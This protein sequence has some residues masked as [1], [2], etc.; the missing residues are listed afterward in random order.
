MG[1]PA[2]L[3]KNY[4]SDLQYTG[5]TIAANEE[6]SDHE[7]WRVADGRRSAQDYWTPTTA[8]AAAWNKVDCAVSRAGD[9][10]ALDRGHNLGGKTI[11]LQKS[12]D[13]FSGDTVDVFTATI[14][15]TVSDDTAL[16]ATNGALTP[17]GAWVKAFTSTSSRY[18]RLL[19]NA[20]GAGEKPQ[21]V[22]WFLGEMW[23]PDYLRM[24]M[25]DEDY[26]LV[27]GETVIPSTGW[28]GR[29]K[30]VQQRLGEV[31]AR[32]ADASAYQTSAEHIRDRF[33]AGYPMW[34]V[35]DD[36]AAE[37]TVLADWTGQQEGF[38]FAL[39][40]YPRQGRFSW[41]ERAAKVA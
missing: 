11:K 35:Y 2:F 5:H 14:P 10:V 34:I 25:P 38:R 6:A 33:F 3:V 13:D 21:V 27:Y 19:V 24:P 29:T 41:T 20:M 39:G 16:T 1:S 37:R 9:M 18:W 40:W 36:A 4:Y 15:T 17:E 30:P 28:R 32:L 23:T 31:N 22:G 8:N 7:A 26:R 12:T